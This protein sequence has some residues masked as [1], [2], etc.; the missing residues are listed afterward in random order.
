[1]WVE[2][3]NLRCYLTKVPCQCLRWTIMPGILSFHTTGSDGASVRYPQPAGSTVTLAAN[4]PTLGRRGA[5]G[6]GP[7]VTLAPREGP[8]PNVR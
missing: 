5:A 1:M 2:D 4:V 7:T 3:T 8:G 6:G